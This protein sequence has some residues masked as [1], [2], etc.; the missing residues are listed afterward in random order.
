MKAT[1]IKTKRLVCHNEK[2]HSHKFYNVILLKLATRYKV[3]TEHGRI[4][5]HATSRVKSLGGWKRATLKS[6]N[7]FLSKE[8]ALAKF[9]KVVEAKIKRGYKARGAA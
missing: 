3:M 2:K 6:D 4:G 9:K 5:G 1:I 7:S 8:D